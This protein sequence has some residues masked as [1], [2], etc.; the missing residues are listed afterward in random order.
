MSKGVKKRILNRYIIVGLQN[1]LQEGGEGYEKM[2]GKG[3]FCLGW[4][5]DSW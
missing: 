4:T 5:D 1:F 3:Y 2:E